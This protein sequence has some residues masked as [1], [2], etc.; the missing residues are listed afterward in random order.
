MPMKNYFFLQAKII[1]RF[2]ADSGIPIFFCYLAIP[3]G[4]VGLA[5]VLFHKTTYAPYLFFLL[6]LISLQIL[7]NTHRN[8]FLRI[9]YGPSRQLTIRSIENLLLVSPFSIY[10]VFRGSWLLALIILPTAVL[11]VFVEFRI[12]NARV[13]PTPFAQFNFEFNALFRKSLIP[14]LGIYAL[15]FIAMKMNNFNLGAASILFLSILILSHLSKPEDD[16]FVWNYS[17]SPQQFLKKKLFSSLFNSMLLFAPA[18]LSLAFYFPE[19]TATLFLFF[20]LGEA[21]IVATLLSKYSSF[22]HEIPISQGIILAL[23]LSIPPALL[24][25]IPFTF[26]RAQSN[27]SSYLK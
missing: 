23:A 13:F 7:S 8:E 24:V 25:F 20:L 6:S 19:N 4:F 21:M 14:L 17:L 27:L 1:H 12:R 2:A 10:L 11:Y 3:I 9:T 5:T 26:K 18:I 22:P 15:A 16:F